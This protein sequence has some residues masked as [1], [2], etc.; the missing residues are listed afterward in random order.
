MTTAPA[1]RST[2]ALAARRQKTGATLQ[3]VHDAPDNRTLYERFKAA[4][5]NL[6]FQDRRS[7]D[8]EAP[9]SSDQRQGHAHTP[10]SGKP[11]RVLHG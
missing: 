8:L 2:A 3:R 7:A 11:T 6:C 5:S 1:P 10:V 4:R 9:T